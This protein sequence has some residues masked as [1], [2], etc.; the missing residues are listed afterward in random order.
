MGNEGGRGWQT[1]V[2]AVCTAGVRM[3]MQGPGSASA[4]F[5]ILW[6]RDVG[7]VMRWWIDG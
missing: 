7:C 5:G 6:V 2:R 3:R 4:L 1:T